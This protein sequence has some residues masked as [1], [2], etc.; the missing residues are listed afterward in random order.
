[1]GTKTPKPITIA[2]L[3][4]LHQ[5]FRH[6]ENH[7]TTVEETLRTIERTVL[8]TIQQRNPIMTDST[9][10]ADI[11]NTKVE[12]VLPPPLLPVGTYLTVIKGL[13]EQGKS[14]QK[15]TDFF[16]FTHRIVAADDDVDMDELNEAFPEGLIDKEIDNTIYV[17][18]KS[19]FVL[20]D[21]IKNCGVEWE[22]KT[23]AAAIDLVPNC[24]VKIFIKHE[25]I[26]DTGR[27]RATVARTLPAAE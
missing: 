24:E 20:T 4:Q 2:N 11:L 6:V 23:V 21:F 14:S 9:N 16:K 10:F 7:S 22:G 18:A 3:V 13:P 12:D 19:A 1:M 27:F 15:Q 25:P 5:Y 17:T 26:G 8:A